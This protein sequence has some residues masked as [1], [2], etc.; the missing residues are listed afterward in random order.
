MADKVKVRMVIYFPHCEVLDLESPVVEICEDF[1]FDVLPRKDETIGFSVDNQATVYD[2]VHELGDKVQPVLL[3]YDMP[4]DCPAVKSRT[5]AQA[6]IA[7]EDF[8]WDIKSIRAKDR[9]RRKS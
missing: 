9:R 4:E 1:H 8:M 7:R 3:C 6:A 2:V 5:A